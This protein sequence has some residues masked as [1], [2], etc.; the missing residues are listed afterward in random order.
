MPLSFFI[1]ARPRLVIPAPHPS[2][3]S[4]RNVIPECL[5]R[6]RESL[7]N[8]GAGHPVHWIPACAGMTRPNDL[9]VR[10]QHLVLSNAH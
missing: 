2:S 8:C 4:R 7:Y 3:F 6:G 1:P 9:A 10:S 5:C